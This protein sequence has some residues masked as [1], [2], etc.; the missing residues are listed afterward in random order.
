MSPCKYVDCFKLRKG[1]IVSGIIWSGVYI[2]VYFDFGLCTSVWSDLVWSVSC[3]LVWSGLIWFDLVHM[4]WSVYFGLI[5]SCLVHVFWSVYFGLVHMPWSVY[6]GLV[7]MWSGPYTPVCVLWSGPY[8][9]VCVLWSGSY[10]VWSIC[11][12]VHIPWS[13]QYAPVWSDLVWSSLLFPVCLI[14]SSHILS[15]CPLALHSFWSIFFDS[16]YL[17]SYWPLKMNVI[18][19]QCYDSGCVAN[20]IL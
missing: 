12:L 11:G 15:L 1:S 9:M 10:M 19:L 7:H 5:L 13:G 18:I 14:Q 17:I 4:P 2:L 8:D 20:S 6:F 3:G 16:L